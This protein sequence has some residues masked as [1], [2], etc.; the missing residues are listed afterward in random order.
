MLNVYDPVVALLNI[1]Y[2]VSF[3]MPMRVLM[4]VGCAVDE[5]FVSFKGFPLLSVIRNFSVHVLLVVEVAFEVG[6]GLEVVVGIG[7]AVG[8]GVG[9]GVGG[10]CTVISAVA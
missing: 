3:V 1:T 6:V 4:P 9:V 7:V 8:F 5:M 2:P 10:G